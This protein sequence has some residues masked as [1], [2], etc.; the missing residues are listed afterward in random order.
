MFAENA[1]CFEYYVCTL[2]LKI[3]DNDMERSVD[4][5]IIKVTSIIFLRGMQ[6]KLTLSSTWCVY[7]LQYNSFL[8]YITSRIK[9]ILAVYQFIFTDTLDTTFYYYYKDSFTHKDINTYINGV[10]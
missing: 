5:K 7:C 4:S 9:I 1:R 2:A 8:V 3:R 6:T 10:V